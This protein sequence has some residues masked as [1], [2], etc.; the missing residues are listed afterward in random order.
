M[1]TIGYENWA[2]DLADVGA[3]YPFQGYE[4]PMVIVGVVFWLGWHII[5]S[6]RESAHIEEAMKIGDPAKI[7][8]MLDRY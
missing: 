5:Q 2:V 3:V 4:L 1:S 8:D 6:K 7:K